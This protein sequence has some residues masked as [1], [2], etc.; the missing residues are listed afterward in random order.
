MSRR[1]ARFASFNSALSFRCESRISCFAHSIIKIDP[2]LPLHTRRFGST[3]S[4]GLCHG[5]LAFVRE[6]YI[7]PIGTSRF[8]QKSLTRHNRV[9]DTFRIYASHHWL[10]APVCCSRFLELAQPHQSPNFTS[11]QRDS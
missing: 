4:G 8:G 7:V 9:I 3:E 1:Y 5:P 2:R 11:L 10:M 6:C